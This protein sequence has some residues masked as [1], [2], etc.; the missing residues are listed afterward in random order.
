MVCLSCRQPMIKKGGRI[1][2]T[3]ESLILAKE[4]S[5]FHCGLPLSSNPCQSCIEIHP[6]WDK[7]C[8]VSDYSYPL[9]SLINQF[10]LNGRIELAKPLAQLL[11]K[12]WTVFQVENKLD[13]VDM[14]I[15]VPTHKLRFIERR[16]NQST[17]LAHFLSTSLNIPFCSDAIFRHWHFYDQ[18]N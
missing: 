3:C 12:A 16:F 14:L 5:C 10:K 11:F 8:Y 6:Q 17:Q 9:N 15:S 4:P 7:L 1:C 2:E 13:S 18:K